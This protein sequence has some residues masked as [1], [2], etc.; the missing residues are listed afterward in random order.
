MAHFGRYTFKYAVKGN[1]YLLDV[2]AIIKYLELKRGNDFSFYLNASIDDVYKIMA[3]DNVREVFFVGHG[4]SHTFVLDNDTE[5]FY[6][7][8]NNEKYKK[9]FVHQVHCGTKHGKSLIDYVVPEENKSKCFFFR[10]EVSSRDIR[11]W[12]KAETKKYKN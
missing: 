3:D 5:I 4:D 11:K 12:F 10:K 9:D 8:F 2:K 7:E 1:Y 6:C